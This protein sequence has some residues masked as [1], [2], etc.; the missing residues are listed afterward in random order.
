MD[1]P[2]T[3]APGSSTSGQ[4][5][6]PAEQQGSASTTL[7]VTEHDRLGVRLAATEQRLRRVE[8]S[9]AELHTRDSRHRV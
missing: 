1:D 9:L 8:E 5:S 7:R 2:I 3:T 6:P 4:Q